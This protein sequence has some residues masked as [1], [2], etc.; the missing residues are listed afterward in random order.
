[1]TSP[2][3][4]YALPLDEVIELYDETLKKN[5][6]YKIYVS[7]YYL[8]SYDGTKNYNPTLVIENDGF[9][10]R[11]VPQEYFRGN[12]WYTFRVSVKAKKRI[13]PD[14]QWLTLKVNNQEWIESDTSSFK[15]GPKPD[16][17]L[18]DQIELTL[19]WDKDIFLKVKK[20][21]TTRALSTSNCLI[22]IYFLH[23]TR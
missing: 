2:E 3:V 18:T 7:N 11:F 9:T 4:G 5:V 6:Q 13:L 8:K 22:Q 19:C 16:S 17:L 14:G 23:Q 15:T 20:L 12:S 10:S 1:M 21:I